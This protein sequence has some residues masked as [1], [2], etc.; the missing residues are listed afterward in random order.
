MTSEAIA[1]EFPEVKT[2][3]PFVVVDAIANEIQEYQK[4]FE[5][6]EQQLQALEQHYHSQKELA[7]ATLNQLRGAIHAL[8]QLIPH[9][10]E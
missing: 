5:A 6:M 1:T 2:L 4:K 7:I 9:K 8:E 3:P 10:T